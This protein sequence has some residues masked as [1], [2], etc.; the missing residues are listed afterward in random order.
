MRRV[1]ITGGPGVGKTTLLAEL[2]ARGY[3]T[4]PESARA[5]IS[6]RR[7]RGQSPRPEPIAFA[8]EILRRDIEKYHGHPRES[9][10][11]FFDRG[12]VE[13]LGMLHEVAPL[14]APELDAKLRAY[15]F[16]SSVFVLPPWKDIYTTDAERDHSFPW[17]EHVHGQLVQ[18]YR[19][20]GYVLHEVPRL[21]V[22][23]RSEFILRALTHGAA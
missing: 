19:S 3:A 16:H 18:W 23:S 2:G 6:E 10:W 22:A 7:A 1:L 8:Q 4:V 12:L 21:P 11:V 5:I 20:C 9:G 13:T 17:V 15:P 14:S